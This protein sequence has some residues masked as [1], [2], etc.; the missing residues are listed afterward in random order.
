MSERFMSKAHLF[1]NGYSLKNRCNVEHDLL[2]HPHRAGLETFYAALLISTMEK[3]FSLINALPKNV[4]N[5][6]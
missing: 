3:P 4:S 6:S 5:S 1:I 2:R